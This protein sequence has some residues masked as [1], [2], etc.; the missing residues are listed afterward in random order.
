MFHQE[1]SVETIK[2]IIILGC[3]NTKSTTDM[4]TEE[5]NENSGSET[6]EST[7]VQDLLPRVDLSPQITEVLLNEMA[8]KNWKVRYE[9][10]IKVNNIIAEAKLIKP[11]IGDLPQALSQRLFDS[12]IKII[13]T[14][15]NICEIIAKNMGPPCRSF[16]RSFLPGLLHG[17]IQIFHY[18]L[19]FK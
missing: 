3:K 9:A 10:L 4:Y 5:E 16:I 15:I 2:M 1:A 18:I 13:Q 6:I 12:N 11:T 17:N 7:S 8:D 14:A 19:C